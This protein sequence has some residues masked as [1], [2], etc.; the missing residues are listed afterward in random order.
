MECACGGARRCVADIVPFRSVRSYPLSYLRQYNYNYNF[1][2][3]R[4]RCTSHMRR[5]EVESWLCPCATARCPANEMIYRYELASINLL[6]YLPSSVPKVPLLSWISQATRPGIIST[7]PSCPTIALLA[8]PLG[9]YPWPGALGSRSVGLLC[10]QTW[11][12][13]TLTAN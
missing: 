11:H 13:I 12:Y 7:L 9:K 3:K 10:M 8:L 4:G 5:L 6:A 2:Y 1:I